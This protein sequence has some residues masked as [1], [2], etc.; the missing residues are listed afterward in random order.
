MRTALLFAMLAVALT[1]PAA[2][3]QGDAVSHPFLC[4][5]NGLGK[6]F[7]VGADGRIEWEYPVE[8][9]QDVW[10][11]PN[12]N[13]LL[14]NLH[15][16]CEVTPAK[17][18]VWEYQAA[19]GVEVHTCQPLADGGVLIGECG[20]KRLIEVD[21]Q[22]AIRKEIPVPTSC[23]VMHLHFRIAR[24]LANGNY[25][26]ACTGEHVVRELGP[27]GQVVRTISVPGDPFI[28]LRLPNGNTL[29]GCGDG[30]RVIEVDAEDKI[31]WELGENELLGIPLRFV[32]G[33]QRLPNGNTVVCN[34]GGHGHIG[35]QPL[36]FEVTRDKR[37]VWQVADYQRFRTISNI[38]LLDVPGDVTQ[39]EV[40]P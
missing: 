17:A 30:H 5:D 36:V 2:A 33:L 10:R 38:Q 4:C 29:I 8:V 19:A 25:L 3:Q 9:G 13:Y 11:L 23:T 32:A 21:R 6:A 40:L 15:G 16:A 24:K 39:G 14:S 7:V 35:E 20:P 37:V 18:V 26:V 12:G 28:G 22:G 1:L 31:V 34:W 27:G